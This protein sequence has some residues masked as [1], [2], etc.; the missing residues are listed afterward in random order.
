MRKGISHGSGADGK[1]CL[2]GQAQ[3][4]YVAGRGVESMEKTPCVACKEPM[5]KE[6]KKC[7]HCG[8][9]NKPDFFS[10][11]GLLILLGFGFVLFVML[12]PRLFI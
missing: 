5:N 4:C 12:F 7:P 6:A 2:Q 9:M 3:L 11:I 1:K 8:T 10:W